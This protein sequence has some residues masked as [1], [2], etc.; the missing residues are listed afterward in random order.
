MK[1][2]HGEVKRDAKVSILTVCHGNAILAHFQ[3]IPRPCVINVK[4]ISVYILSGIACHLFSRVDILVTKVP[5]GKGG[6]LPWR[7][8]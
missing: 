5:N 7:S 8:Q 1:D 3:A 4:E 6:T 2:F